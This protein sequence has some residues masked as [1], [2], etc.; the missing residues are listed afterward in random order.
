LCP[1]AFTTTPL[2]FFEELNGE[3]F[4]LAYAFMIGFDA[5]RLRDFDGVRRG[6]W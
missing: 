3:L 1:F 6:G 5:R 4:V 2:G